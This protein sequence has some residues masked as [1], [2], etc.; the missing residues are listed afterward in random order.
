MILSNLINDSFCLLSKQLKFYA[1]Q[2]KR[3]L[4]QKQREELISI[5]EESHFEKLAIKIKSLHQIV[6]DS[7]QQIG[8][9]LI[10]K[11]LANHRRHQLIQ[12]IESDLVDINVELDSYGRTLLHRAAYNLDVDL[13]K[14][15][16]DR[17]V[18][19]KLRDF[20][21]HTALHVAIQSYRNGA[22]MFNNELKVVQNLSAIIKLL[23]DADKVCATRC[24]DQDTSTDNCKRIK[25]LRRRSGISED[26]RM[27]P[28]QDGKA[29]STSETN[30]FEPLTPLDL[31]KIHYRSSRRNAITPSGAT[32]ICQMF[33][34]QPCKVHLSQHHELTQSESHNDQSSTLSDSS[35]SSEASFDRVANPVR[36]SSMKNKASSNMN[37]NNANLIDSR[38]NRFI[39]YKDAFGRTALH[40]CVLVVGEKHLN[41]FV[42]LLL[43]NGADPDSI[44][45]RLKTP[46]YCLVKRPNFEAVRQKCHAIETLVTHG[47]DDLGLALTSSSCFSEKTVS[48]VEKN[49]VNILQRR[50]DDQVDKIFTSKTYRRVPSLKHIARL[51]LIRENDKQTGCTGRQTGLVLPSITPYTLNYYVNRKLLDQSELF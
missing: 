37:T 42:K 51:S 17:R 22:I 1:W 18:N 8:H 7:R 19:I 6:T 11:C 49:I 26:V 35:S 12:L 38:P 10:V 9:I 23:L 4:D 32:T 20:S 30:E 13:V 14:L 44:D 43:D 40:Y 33:R 27:S 15:L 5:L 50:H 46:L 28:V 3:D 16:I 48:E 2:Y 31:G 39:N 24:D 41:H 34:S 25:L 47:C 45:V 36:Q 29:F 21:G